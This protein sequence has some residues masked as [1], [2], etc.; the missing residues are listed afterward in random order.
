MNKKAQYN[1]F[2]CVCL[3]LV[4]F[5]LPCWNLPVNA[6]GTKYLTSLN[7]SSANN[8]E[9]KDDVTASNETEYK[10]G[11]IC[12]DASLK[13]CNIVYK[14]NKKYLSLTA[15]LTPGKNTNKGCNFNVVFYGDG[16]KLKEFK[17]ITYSKQQKVTIDVTGVKKLKIA[18][19]NSGTWYN[20]FVY[21]VNTKLESCN[22]TVSDSKLD[23]NVGEMT[24]VDYTYD[25]DKSAKATWK[26][27]DTSVAIVSSK[28][29][30][31]AVGTGTC[32]ITCK[33]KKETKTISVYVN[34]AKVTGLKVKSK[35]A[36]FVQLK[37]DAQSNASGYEVWRYD[38]DFKEYIKVKTIKKGGTNSVRITGLKKGTNYKFQV[39]SYL[40]IEKKNCYGDYSKV[41]KVKTN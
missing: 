33:V 15:I 22:L 18:A 8:C 19:T 27:S 38:D 6:A 32:T 34:P 23:L 25:K 20:G 17:G 1:L 29:Q 7:Y 40:K 41:L 4:L 3:A 28:G 13:D 11:V 39:R 12:F 5:L 10:K 14:L 21:L 26:S 35:G 24:F 36:N 9:P 37:W 31:K 30:I 16:K 2:I